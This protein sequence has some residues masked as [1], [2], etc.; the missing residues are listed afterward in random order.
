M[1]LPRLTYGNVVSTLALFIALSGVS[2]A[3]TKIK[4]PKNSVGS[5]QIK[6]SAVT[7]SKI[8]NNTITSNDIKAG[9]IAGD[10]INIGSL[11]TVPRAASAG[12]ADN[13]VDAAT[14]VVKRVNPSADNPSDAVARTAATP[15]ELVS[16][17]AVSI[18]G[19][20]FTS[21]GNLYA[22]TFAATSQ[23]GAMLTRGIGAPMVGNP[24][25]NTGTGETAR[26][27]VQATAGSG[28]VSPGGG[29]PFMGQTVAIGPDG[30]GF[31]ASVQTYAKN[32]DIIFGNGPYG[33][34]Q[35]CLFAANGTKF[36]L[37]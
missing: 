14:P 35:V 1:R 18:Y 8:K 22:E 34:G 12:T 20:C 29:P 2:Y 32:G 6:R 25:L 36:N 28:S 21:A 33:V 31:D 4:V 10:R 30:K 37:G 26:T 3:A 9:A 27:V 16:H 15:I 17:G 7:S 24:Y 5:K 13:W 23:D 11:G 19:K